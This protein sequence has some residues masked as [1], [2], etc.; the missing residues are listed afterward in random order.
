MVNKSGPFGYVP[1]P[2][3]IE[4]PKSVI[5]DRS[6]SDVAGSLLPPEPSAPPDALKE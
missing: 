1:S 6:K 3:N 2:P 5:C 4:L